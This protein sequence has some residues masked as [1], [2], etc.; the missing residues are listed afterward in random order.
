MNE[1]CP[2]RW[3]SPG[4]EINLLSSSSYFQSTGMHLV[5]QHITSGDCICI[6][7]ISHP[8]P[9]S[10]TGSLIFC[11]QAERAAAS[12]G[13]KLPADFAAVAAA[14]G[15]RRSVLQS[16]AA[17]Q[18][19]ALLGWLSRAVPAARDRLLADPRYLFIVV[20]EVLIDS[21]ANPASCLWRLGQLCRQE[22]S[23][24]DNLNMA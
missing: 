9:R 22:S 10:P 23:P 21:G 15:L 16:Y 17:L 1:P 18:R 13:F 11:D 8:V 3:E 12:S 19:S 4:F 6:P 14:E 24:L 7:T 5:R 20:S 2:T